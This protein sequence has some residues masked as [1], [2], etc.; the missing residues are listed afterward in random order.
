MYPARRA[1][2]GFFSCHGLDSVFISEDLYTA[3]LD[4]CFHGGGFALRFNLFIS[5]LSRC[6]FRLR[7][8]L[9]AV[10]F[11]TVYGDLG[12]VEQSQMDPH[13]R[14]YQGRESLTRWTRICFNIIN[15]RYRKL[16]S[17]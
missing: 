13:V 15:I 9:F 7:F 1:G 14:T 5:I 4:F 16:E 12:S 2:D 3:Y 17:E 10:V 8:R 6:V 11:F